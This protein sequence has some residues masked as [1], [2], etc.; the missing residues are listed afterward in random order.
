MA[1]QVTALT[2]YFQAP[3]NYP[4]FVQAVGNGILYLVTTEHTVET[5]IY[6]GAMARA[7]NA[8]DGTELWTLS[9]YTG[10]FSAISYAI[11]GRLFSILQRL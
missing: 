6:K 11:A 9:D 7:I 3:G 10:E 2:D 8:T 5:P 1:D 4:T